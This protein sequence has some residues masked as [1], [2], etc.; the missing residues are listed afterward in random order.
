MANNKFACS[1]IDPKLCVCLAIHDQGD[2]MVALMTPLPVYY[3][4][5]Y[6]ADSTSSDPRPTVL[7]TVN[8]QQKHD[9]E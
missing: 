4:Q 7:T 5:T 3:S 8:L 6:G 9:S 2:T 1:C